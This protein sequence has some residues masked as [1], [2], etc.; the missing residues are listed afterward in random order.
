MS[1]AFATQ[2]ELNLGPVLSAEVDLVAIRQ[3]VSDE[4]PFACPD[5]DTPVR[6]SQQYVCPKGHVHPEREM[7]RCFVVDDSNTVFVTND[8]I[9]EIRT[10]N[11]AKKSM[12]LSVHP[13]VEVEAVTVADNTAYRC[14]LG[15]NA[16]ARQRE[17]YGLLRHVAAN[18]E[19]ALIGNLRIKDSR[20]LYRLVVH[21][22]QLTVISLVL[23]EVLAE[24]DELDLPEL[25]EA[26]LKMADDLVE[27][28]V[29]PFHSK[30]YHHDVMA[31][32][33][34][35]VGRERPAEPEPQPV[36]TSADA[37]LIA[38]LESSLRATQVVKPSRKPRA[39]RATATTGPRK[40]A[41]RKPA[42]KE[43]P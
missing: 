8:E 37:D 31:A 34:E 24:T 17:L 39:S 43:A 21:R 2:V 20:K 29:E 19:F 41:A 26:A 25:P 22:D 9:E 1:R 10:A 3:S 5:H 11:A 35:V 15:K 33:A 4:F 18:P 27:N 42:A 16:S 7:K 6:V 32:V 13:A 28:L 30:M 40:R 36:A 38:A 23:P 12:T 14:R